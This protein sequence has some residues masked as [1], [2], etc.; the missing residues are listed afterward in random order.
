ML[1]LRIYAAYQPFVEKPNSIIAEMCQWQI[2]F[3]LFCFLLIKTGTVSAN[4]TIGI[5]LLFLN[6]GLPM[7][8]V[9]IALSDTA[10]ELHGKH[11]QHV[12]E[13]GQQSE[14]E[15]GRVSVD[16][17]QSRTLPTTGAPPV[18][19]S[20]PPSVPLNYINNT[21]NHNINNDGCSTSH[22]PSHQPKKVVDSDEDS[23]HG[24]WAN[25]QF[26]KGDFPMPHD[27]GEE[28]QD[29]RMNLL[30]LDEPVSGAQ[31]VSSSGPLDT[32]GTITPKDSVKSTTNNNT[33]AKK[34]LN[35]Y[36]A[37]KIVPY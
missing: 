23:M 26:S 5:V 15:R 9:A 27:A 14:E 20:A 21:T 7:A 28:K 31:T 3:T 36:N 17:Q 34:G 4:A 10:Y 25:T 18:D 1:A 8:G 32:S 11:Q 2:F 35:G 24:K 19:N 12:F 33:A 22:I 13:K 6:I 16:Q 29:S 30:L 37:A